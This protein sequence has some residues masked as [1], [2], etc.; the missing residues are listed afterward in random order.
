[1]KGILRKVQKILDHLD[2]SESSLQQD[3]LAS[4]HLRLSN[5][6]VEHAPV[7]IYWILPDAT[8]FYANNTACLSLGLSREE[9]VGRSVLDINPGLDVSSWDVHW[10]EIK[11]TQKVTLETEHKHKSG[12]LF[13]VEI[14]AT[15]LAFNGG[16]YNFAIARDITDLKVNEREKEDARHQVELLMAERARV[17]ESAL[18]ISD[19]RLRLAIEAS[20]AGVWDW[21]IQTGETYCSPAYLE[22]WVTTPPSLMP[23]SNHFS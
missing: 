10:Q 23:V 16:E 18:A 1:M 15:Y 4:D 9:L 11:N 7:A 2:P 17:L 20:Q 12:K 5:L 3:S 21:N 8:I 6:A 14:T 13:P 22:C 19:E